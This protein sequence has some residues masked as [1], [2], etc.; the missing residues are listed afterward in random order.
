MKR[1]AQWKKNQQDKRKRQKTLK[2]VLNLTPDSI[3]DSEAEPQNL[4][5]PHDNQEPL[6]LPHD[7]QDEESSSSPHLQQDPLPLASSTPERGNMNIISKLKKEKSVLKRQLLTMKMQLD[8]HKRKCETMRKCLNRSFQM[9]KTV[10]ERY[11][12]RGGKKLAASRKT[13]VKKF[14]CRDDHSRILPGKRDTMTKGKDKQ[15]RRVLLKNLKELHSMYNEEVGKEM[16][17][18]YRQ[19][20]RLRPFFVTEPKTRDRNTCACLDH[21]NVRLLAEKLFHNGVLETSSISSLLSRIACDQKKKECMHRTCPHCCYSEI[22]VTLPVDKMS[23]ETTWQQWRREKVNKDDKTYNNIVKKVET[24]SWGELVSMFNKALDLLAKHHFNWLHQLEECRKLKENLTDTEVVVHIDF[25]ENYGCKLSTE[26][27]AFHF[28]GS[29]KQ[30]TIHTCVVYTKQGCQSYATISDSLRHDERAVW[31]HL[32]PSL[33]KV[34]EENPT[35]KSVH[36][37]SDGTVT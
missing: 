3:N 1:R 31:A 14:L 25:S 37:L 36:F 24:G 27:Q 30:A 6:A 35:I 11:K 7:N 12:P 20:V 29:R 13:E 17:M 18:S 32:E 26:I 2:A 16:K 22:E 8:Q 10:N 9:K 5:L 33:K 34:K 28:G 15:Q 19:F 23:T 21:E 4:P